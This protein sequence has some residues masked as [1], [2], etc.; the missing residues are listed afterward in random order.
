MF[1]QRALLCTAFMVGM[2]VG[3][4]GTALAVVG[5]PGPR[6]LSA[7]YASDDNTIHA[8]FGMTTHRVWLP[9]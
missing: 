9:S 3:E 2:S 7:F 5:A 4:T 6:T 8:I 1:I